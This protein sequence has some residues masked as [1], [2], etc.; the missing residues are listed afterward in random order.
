MGAWTPA[1]GDIPGISCTAHQGGFYLFVNGSALLGKRTPQGV[2]IDTDEEFTSYLLESQHVA[3][4]HGSAYGTP[5]YFRISFA[6]SSEVLD[7]AVA[8]IG[9]AC[10]DLT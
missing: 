7:E 8:R 4:I 10:A 9:R 3:V 2:V 1:L 5:G 6:T